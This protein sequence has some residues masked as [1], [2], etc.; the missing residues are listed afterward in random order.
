MARAQAD[1]AEVAKDSARQVAEAQAE[2]ARAVRDASREIIEAEERVRDTR[3]DVAQDT[4]DANDSVMG[5][6]GK[7]RGDAQ[8][9]SE[10]LLRQ[11]ERQVKDQEQWRANLVSLAG[12]VPPEMLD[13]LA[14]LGPGAA[15]IV[16][17]A[18]Q[19]SDAELAKLIGLYGRSGKSAG[20]EFAKNLDEAQD[21]LRVIGYRHGQQVADKVRE[22]MDN[23]RIGVFE[24]ARRIGL[25]IDRGIMGDRVVTIRTEAQEFAARISQQADGGILDGRGVKYF[26]DGDEH[27]VAQISSAGPIRMWAEPETGGEAYIPLAMSKRARSEDILSQVAERFG[28]RFYRTMPVSRTPVSVGGGGGGMY[29][30]APVYNIT[31]HGGLD[32]GPE[33]GRQVVGAI[34]EFERRSGDGWRR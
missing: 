32:S 19:M 9:T 20:D 33:I 28:G 25:E 16:A 6:W 22:A 14:K 23:G 8:L 12:R 31:V 26:A 29:R 11:L 17:T 4:R 13:E 10:E 24:A 7:L 5:S 15:G 27:H 3:K 34:Q 18:A 21:V 30:T 2:A 1:A